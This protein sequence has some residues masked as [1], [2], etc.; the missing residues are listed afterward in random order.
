MSEELGFAREWA[1]AALALVPLYLWLRRRIERRRAVAF[2]PLQYRADGSRP[3]YLPGLALALE[4][5]LL[6]TA[7]VGFAGPERRQRV[8]LFE[9]DGVDV[10]L[11][12][13][14]SLSMLADDFEPNRI[15][16]LREIAADF[17]R[18]G[19]GHR[20]AVVV[21]AGEAYVQTPLTT[22]HGVLLELMDGVTVRTIDQHLSG[23]T[24]IGDALLVATE[25]LRRSRIENRDQALV[26]ITDGES[27][28]GSEPVL[29]GR[30]LAASGIRFYAIGVGGDEPVEVVFDG[31]RIGG[32]D[33]Y[34]AVLDEDE[35]RQ[36]AEV[37]AGRF[38]RAG[39]TRA[40]DEIFRELSRL[41]SAPFEER[42][43][44]TRASFA[45]RLALVA[46][47]LF[48]AHLWLGGVVLRS[49]YR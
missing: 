35:L 27:N 22:D 1:L 12:L 16:A 6:A 29:A 26:L 11:V 8:E 44:E 42:V 43:L 41:E 24:A 45:P 39:D 10:A 38:Y 14:V 25:H 21:F 7:L 3:R 2:A 46:L 15:E 48:A 19:G 23:G 5:L 37:T 18:R 9:G 34:L 31:E 40:L 32:D 47:A 30:Y 13:D 36:L 33:P 4:G 28:A 17:I 49:P 20:V